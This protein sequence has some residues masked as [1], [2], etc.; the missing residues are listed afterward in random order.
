M[1]PVYRFSLDGF[2]P[3]RQTY[4]HRIYTHI[5]TPPNLEGLNEYQ[6][7]MVL[8]VWE[9]NKEAAQQLNL[10]DW[11]WGYWVFA[12]QRP[13]PEEERLEL[14]HLTSTNGYQWFV[15]ELDP[16]TVVYSPYGYV[17]TQMALKD[18]RPGQPV[19]IPNRS[20]KWKLNKHTT[21]S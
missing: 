8:D 10:D 2:V 3:K 13:D 16:L 21:P 14:N 1:I 5:Q 7:G 18:T 6:K 11:L 4:H 12:K 9:K 19:Y 20:K 15:C 17:P